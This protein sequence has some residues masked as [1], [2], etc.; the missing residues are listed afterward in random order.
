MIS[1]LTSL[2]LAATLIVTT[3]AQQFVAVIETNPTYFASRECYDAAKYYTIVDFG[4]TPAPA[5]S[6]SCTNRGTLLSSR[7]GLAT[8][9]D[10]SCTDGKWTNG[11]K[12]CR[13]V[14]GVIAIH[15]PSGKKQICSAED[16]MIYN[17][18]DNPPACWTN[19]VRTFSCVGFWL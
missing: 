3:S 10:T 6:A 8:T 14:E 5:T 7:V 4:A 9:M 1:P 18:P 17:C 11:Y 15:H 2:L 12:V 13:V 19:K 16:T